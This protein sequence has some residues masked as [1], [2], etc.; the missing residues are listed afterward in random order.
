MPEFAFAF[1]DCEFG[2]LDAELHDITEIGVIEFEHLEDTGSEFTDYDLVDGTIGG[3]A[4]AEV[5]S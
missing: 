1:M 5:A 4:G 3:E 2:G